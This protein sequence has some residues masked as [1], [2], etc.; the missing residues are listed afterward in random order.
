[1]KLHILGC[2]SAVPTLR[3]RSTAQILNTDEQLH[4]I[5]CGEGT[6]IQMLKYG[7]SH[8]KIHNIFISHLH[9]D[10]YFGLIGLLNTMGLMG[11]QKPLRLIGPPQL[12][13]IIQA[14]QTCIDRSFPFELDFIPLEP[15]SSELILDESRLR[16]HS[17]PTEHSIPCHGFRFDLSRDSHKLLPE[18]CR[19]HSIPVRFYSSIKE[20]QDYT[21]PEGKVIPHNELTEPYDFNNY[22]YAYTADTSYAP[23]IIPHI[24]GVHTLYHESTYLEDKISKAQER[25]HSTAL[26]AAQIAEKAQA[27]RLVLGH[28]SSAYADTDKF[29]REASPVFGHT[30]AA[31]DGLVLPWPDHDGEYPQD[32]EPE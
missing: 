20:G 10:H 16:V 30:I 23:D 19:E 32:S 17:F 4:L 29:V 11:R 3:R 27:D 1:M 13:D 22:S 31:Y 5:D 15:E 12:M 28:F 21:T 7:L 24:Q 25:K 26:Q 6:Q 9:G 18:K 14:H 8:F 2:N